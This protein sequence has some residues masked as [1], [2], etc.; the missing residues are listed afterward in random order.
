MGTRFFRI[1][2]TLLRVFVSTTFHLDSFLLCKALDFGAFFAISPN[3][4][5]TFCQMC[6]GDFGTLTCVK[7][8][9]Y[10]LSYYSD[11]GNKHLPLPPFFLRLLV[12]K[13]P[14]VVFSAQFR[15][16]L[17]ALSASSG[18]RGCPPLTPTN[19]L[20]S[21]NISTY[22]C[23]LLIKSTVTKSGLPLF[24]VPH[25]IFSRTIKCRL[26]SFALIFLD[27][28]FGRF[29]SET[30]LNPP[31]DNVSELTPSMVIS[32]QVSKPVLLTGAVG[33]V[34]SGLFFFS[35][36]NVAHPTCP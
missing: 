17:K 4:G 33:F 1:S 5:L 8:G 2:N 31:R 19:L 32:V 24:L 10:R 34:N 21:K 7:K 14:S 27:L 11:R 13:P 9:A 30:F 28:S 16:T 26:S 15:H 18:R 36:S 35:R 22:L 23:H 29:N 12:S 3:R 6:K 20:F 25:Y